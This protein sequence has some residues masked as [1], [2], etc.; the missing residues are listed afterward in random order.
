MNE[1]RPG[2]FLPLPMH[3]GDPTAP[4][5]RA[6]TR[7]PVKIRVVYVRYRDPNPLEFPDRPEKLAGPLFHAAGVLLR[8]DDEFLALGEIAFAE[9]NRPLAQRY[10]ADL[11]PAY[12]NVLTIPKAA[13]IARWNFSEPSEDRGSPS[14]DRDLILDKRKAEIAQPPPPMRESRTV[15]EQNEHALLDARGLFCPM[16]I[17]KASAMIET[18][19]PGERLEILADDPAA[20]SDFEAFSKR[21]GHPLREHSEDSGTYRFVLEH[22]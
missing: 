6:P 20:P 12:R 2:L 22:K 15:T 17:L 9:E 5:D 19:Q 18:L 10:G 11:F 4:G 14:P 16:P 8:E 13:I 7:S 21:T 1:D 3:S